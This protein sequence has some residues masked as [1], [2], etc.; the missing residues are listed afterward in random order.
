MSEKQKGEQVQKRR[1]YSINPDK[2]MAL[3]RCSLDMS[4]QIGKTVPRQAILDALIDCLGDKTVYAKV[5]KI[6]TSL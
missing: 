3:S 1:T 6:I 2:A 4:E 5:V